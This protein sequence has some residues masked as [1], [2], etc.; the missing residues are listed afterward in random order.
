MRRKP[1]SHSFEE[2]LSSAR[3]YATRSEWQL[4]SENFL[5]GYAS[6]R[7]WIDGCCAHMTKGPSSVVFSVYAYKFSDRTAYVG[8]SRNLS[9][10][11][12]GHK[13]SGP[14]R[15]KIKKMKFEYEVIEK[16]VSAHGAGT[17]ETYWWDEL[18]KSFKMINRRKSCGILGPFQEVHKYSFDDCLKSAQNFSTKVDWW[19][20]QDGHLYAYARRKNWIVLCCAHMKT[21][22]RSQTEC[23]DISRNYGNLAELRSSR[24]A[25][26][27]TFASRRGWKL[28]FGCHSV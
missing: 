20:S 5:Y 4:S 25:K 18:S 21:R 2:C 26:V 8:I 23:S 28:E 15:D 11:E 24:D 19:R 7:G 9:A 16:G 14:L 22:Q 27:Y 1:I 17:R 10:R 6:R 13:N 12:K 3:R